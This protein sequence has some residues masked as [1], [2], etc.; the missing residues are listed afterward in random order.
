MTTAQVKQSILYKQVQLL[1][2]FGLSEAQIDL[3]IDLTCDFAI[4]QLH[5]LSD[6]IGRSK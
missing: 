2:S 1:E 4:Q 5:E 3:V 6:S